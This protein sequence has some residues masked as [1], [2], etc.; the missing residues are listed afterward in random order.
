M[1]RR[2]WSGRQPARSITIGFNLWRGSS[3]TGY[4]L[5]INDSLIP[6]KALSSV[7]EVQ[8]DYMTPM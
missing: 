6:N 8:Y 2:F 7:L 1:E 4:D 5:R 3:E